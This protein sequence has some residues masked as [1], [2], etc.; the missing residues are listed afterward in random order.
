MC[1]T[2]SIHHSHKLG[3]ITKSL[4]CFA[5]V[6][7]FAKHQLLQIGYGTST[8]DAISGGSPVGLELGLQACWEGFQSP[9]LVLYFTDNSR[10]FSEFMLAENSP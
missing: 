4:S 3:P 8:V 9:Q 10:A 7:E 1:T 6:Q 2:T 5:N